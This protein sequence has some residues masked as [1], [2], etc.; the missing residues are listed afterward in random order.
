MLF[1][2]Q[3]SK[4]LPVGGHPHKIINS[5]ADLGTCLQKLQ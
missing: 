2:S 5:V 4:T 1:G 3:T